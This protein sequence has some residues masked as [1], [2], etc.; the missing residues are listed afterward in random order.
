MI[1]SAVVTSTASRGRPG[2]V[3][4]L[5][6]LCC[7]STRWTFL[8]TKMMKAMRPRPPSLHSAPMGSGHLWPRYNDIDLTLALTLPWPYS[9][10]VWFSTDKHR[11]KIVWLCFWI[12]LWS[13]IAIFFWHWFHVCRFHFCIIFQALKMAC[14]CC[15]YCYCCYCT[16]RVQL[17]LEVLF[18]CLVWR[19][20][21]HFAFSSSNI[22][23]S[24]SRLHRSC[25]RMWWRQR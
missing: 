4:S 25:W 16:W 3:S 9:L 22:S 10:L 13:L 20:V 24:P 1:T 2:V 7:P 6:R 17:L 12:V 8:R 18:A 5:P 23:S 11:S 19:S 15:C 21:F 14:C